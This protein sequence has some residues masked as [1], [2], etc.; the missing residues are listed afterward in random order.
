MKI[1]RVVCT[2]GSLAAALGCSETH[3]SRALGGGCSDGEACTCPD[4]RMGHEVCDLDT[5]E[6]VM[7]QC[8]DKPQQSRTNAEEDAGSTLDAGGR[9]MPG[10]SAP[11]PAGHAADGGRG[12][13][14]AGAPASPPHR[15]KG[16]DKKA[17]KDAGAEDDQS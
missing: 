1:L 8:P 12:G 15:G 6:T 5:H 3:S 13:S 7:C 4:G 14:A 11:V 10:Q 16:Q 17:H 2:L 9:P